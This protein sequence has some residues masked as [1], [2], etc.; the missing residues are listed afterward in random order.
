MR[1]VLVL[2]QSYMPISVVSLKRAMKY[3]AKEKAEVI[4]EYNSTIRSARATW[5]IPAVVR[6][7]VKF[8]RPRKMVKFSRKNVYARD[9]WHCQYCRQKFEPVELTYD[10]VVPKSRGGKT[11]WNN[12][13]TACTECN[14]KKGD[15]TPQEA[16]MPL[17]RIPTKPDWVPIFVIKLMRDRHIPEQ[18][19]DF[20]YGY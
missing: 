15:R 16:R 12:I 5:K 2:D 3:L 14:L 18:W 6:F 10:H 19:R 20:C 17:Y 13:V 11:E 8:K 7:I 4:K 9:R 1:K